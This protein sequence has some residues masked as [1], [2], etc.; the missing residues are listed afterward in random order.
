M[1]VFVLIDGFFGILVFITTLIYIGQF[2]S[3]SKKAMSVPARVEGHEYQAQSLLVL[4]S[5]NQSLVKVA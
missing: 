4:A 5:W 1:T 3:K 2:H